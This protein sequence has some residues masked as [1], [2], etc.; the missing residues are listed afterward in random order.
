MASE[1][2]TQKQGRREVQARLV[3]ATPRAN[4]WGYWVLSA[5]TVVFLGWLWVDL[6]A[7]FGPILWRPLDLLLGALAYVFLIVLPCGYGAHRFVT[8]FPRVF[9]QAGW[10]VQPC[11]PLRPAEQYAVRY[12]F[13]S[14]ERANTDRRRIPVAGSAGMGISGNRRNTCRLSGYDSSLF[15][16]PGVRIRELRTPVVSG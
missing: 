1:V 8:S 3:E 13:T 4:G 16:R 15:Q 7:L 9:Q 5:P 12:V 14:Q 6:F 10:R 2:K 11:E